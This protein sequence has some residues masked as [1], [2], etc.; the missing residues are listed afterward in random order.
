MTNRIRIRAHHQIDMRRILCIGG[1]DFLASDNVLVT[2]S[3]GTTTN[4]GKVCATAWLAVALAKNDFPFDRARDKLFFLSGS[5]KHQDGRCSCAAPERNAGIAIKLL[6]NHKLSRPVAATTTKLFWP[7]PR[8][9]ALLI[10]LFKEITNG[11]SPALSTLTCG[12]LRTYF[13]SEM[14]D[15]KRLNIRA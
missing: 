5:A 12:I 15:K 1:V 14:L 11:L 3:L 6:F 7:T 10:H 8:K 4:T 13:F 9:P 2:H